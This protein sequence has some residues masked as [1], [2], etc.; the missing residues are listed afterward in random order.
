MSYATLVRTIVGLQVQCPLVDTDIP[1]L[2]TQCLKVT[3]N[4]TTFMPRDV[5]TNMR[6]QV[7]MRATARCIKLLELLPQELR[8]DILIIS[9]PDHIDLASPEIQ[10]VP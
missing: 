6:R 4:E 2:L 7:V 9:V 1:R 10:F 8:D 5:A 3:Q